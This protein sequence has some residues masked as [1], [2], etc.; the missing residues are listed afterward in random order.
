MLAFYESVL[1]QQGSLYERALTSHWLPA[2]S[3]EAAAGDPRLPLEQLQLDSLIKPFRQFVTE[4]AT[5]C[6][7]AL[8][9]TAEDLKRSGKEGLRQALESILHGRLTTIPGHKEVDTEE[10]RP[11]VE[12]FPRAFLQPVAESLAA[13]SPRLADDAPSLGQTCPRCYR[14]PQV[15]VLQDEQETKGRRFLECSLCATRW[16]FP[17]LTCPGCLETRSNQLAHHLS[18]R[19]PYLRIEECKSNQALSTGGGVSGYDTSPENTHLIHCTVADNTGFVGGGAAFV[20]ATHSIF[21]NNI[22]T[23]PP[24]FNPQAPDCF[25]LFSY[26]GYNLITALGDCNPTGNTTGN[27]IGVDPLFENSGF[28]FDY[29]LQPTSPAID[30][31]DPTF[32]PCTTDAEGN[33]RVLDGDPDQ[34]MVPDLGAHEFTNARLDGSVSPLRFVVLTVDGRVGMKAF[35]LIGFGQAE[36]LLARYGCLFVDLPGL[37]MQPMPFTTPTGV[38]GLVSNDV[39]EGF[40]MTFQALTL[41]GG[42]GNLTNV[43]ELTF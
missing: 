5:T 7:E 29:R 9:A 10:D 12:F 43:V 39:P 18:D 24:Q 14:P 25:E 36:S 4:V 27:L 6:T 38:S 13:N 17:R 42:A 40:T 28:P 20:Y 30:A 37:L 22:H 21:A 32:L 2:G 8:A 16:P 11:R 31:G 23:N 3:T 35:L 33:S 19:T 26:G 41:E 15:A 1:Q 34:V